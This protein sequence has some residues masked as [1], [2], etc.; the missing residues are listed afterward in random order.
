MA[1][2]APLAPV[3]IS[4]HES[5]SPLALL[6]FYRVML[7]P[8]TMNRFSS[9]LSSPLV[10][11]WMLRRVPWATCSRRLRQVANH[12]SRGLRRRPPCPD[13]ACTETTSTGRE[14]N[15]RKLRCGLEVNDG[16]QAAP[17]TDAGVEPQLRGPTHRMWTLCATHGWQP[18]DQMSWV[19]NRHF[20]AFLFGLTMP[21][22]HERGPCSARSTI[23]R[24]ASLKPSA[25]ESRP[26]SSRTK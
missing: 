16:R 13:I 18:V 10:C 5:R 12:G 11:R 3:D 22:H 21:W 14:G 6:G 19:S 4:G 1:N 8:Q 26:T 23:S 2:S 15:S 17:E 20:F 9:I 25:S 7:G 24:T